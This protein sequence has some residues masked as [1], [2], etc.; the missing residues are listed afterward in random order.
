M[1]EVMKDTAGKENNGH[2]VCSG[3]ARLV[4][5]RIGIMGAIGMALMRTMI[6][7]MTL[8]LENDVEVQDRE[9]AR[10]L[11][12][13]VYVEGFWAVITI[14]DPAKRMCARAWMVGFFREI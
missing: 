3:M 7:M 9:P 14:C 6:L 5:G 2:C 12:H 13:H 10:T 1:I 11:A 4:C 8:V